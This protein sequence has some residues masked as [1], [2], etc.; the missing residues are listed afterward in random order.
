MKTTCIRDVKVVWA[1]VAFAQLAFA[2]TTATSQT[3]LLPQSKPPCCQ[4]IA[5]EKPLTEHSAYQ[6]PSTWTTDAEKNIKLTQLRGKPQV[7]AM[8]FASC[9]G[10]CPIL[11]EQMRQLVDSLPANVRTNVGFVLISFDSERDTPKALRAYRETRKLPE[12]Q[13]TLLHGRAEDVRELALVLGV[14]YRQDTNGQ[15][16]HSNLITILNSEGEIAY[17]QNGLGRP[18]DELAKHVKVL[19]KL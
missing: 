10:A 6:L 17:Q 3:N 19:V 13:W 14:K 16:S 11:V 12:G 4:E 15:F 9:N 1:F 18:V 7:V 2:A 8:F 5:S